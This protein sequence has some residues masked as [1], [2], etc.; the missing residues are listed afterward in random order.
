MLDQLASRRGARILV[1]EDN[2]LNQQVISDLLTDAGFVVEVAEHGAIALDMLANKPYALVLMDMQMP[3]MDGLTSTRLL[4]ERPAL[5]GLPVLAM[6]ANAMQADRERC[7]Q[8]GMNDH[9]S[10]PIEPDALWGGLAAVAA[11]PCR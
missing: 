9:L 6:T 4:R 1:V 2:E 5:A 8:A 11:R 7:L 10:K 3:V